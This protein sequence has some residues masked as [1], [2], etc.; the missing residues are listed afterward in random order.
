VVDQEFFICV[1]EYFPWNNS[2]LERVSEKK[3]GSESC[4]QYNY[5]KNIQDN[6]FLINC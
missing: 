6:L 4:L 1:I 2:F 3:E 5:I